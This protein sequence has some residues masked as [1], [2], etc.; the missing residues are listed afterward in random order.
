MYEKYRDSNL[1]PKEYWEEHAI[2]YEKATTTKYH[3]ERLAMIE[4][5]LQNVD[6]RNA[7]ILDFGC[8]GGSEAAI[9]AKSGAI[10]HGIDISDKMVELANTR[11]HDQNLIGS[12]ELGDVSSLVLLSDDSFDIIHCF[13][14]LG[15]LSQ[16]QVVEFYR[17]CRRLLR[18]NGNLLISNS[19][20]LFDI[21]TF[22]SCTI[23]FYEKYFVSATDI[24][25]VEKLITHSESP[26]GRTFNY[27]ANPLSY[28]YIMKEYGFNEVQQEYCHFHSRPPLLLTDGTF[29]PTP[30]LSN[31]VKWKLYF[32]C[33]IYGSRLVKDEC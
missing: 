20:E 11:F 5:M 25:A 15:Y 33:S 1:D 7:N 19:N 14:V 9:H 12:F 23:S 18:V 3:L 27:R 2:D 32:Q 17:Q 28:K 21:F 22:N 16:E 26:T 13:N 8:G 31:E 24:E 10:I 6:V 30:E 29:E 4:R